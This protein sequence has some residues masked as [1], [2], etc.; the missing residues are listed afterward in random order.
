MSNPSEQFAEKYNKRAIRPIIK[1]LIR[2]GKA[3]IAA[4]AF[5]EIIERFFHL[6]P[7]K[8]AVT[9]DGALRYM[10]HLGS[11]KKGLD[12]FCI[13]C[14]NASK[15]LFRFEDGSRESILLEH[16]KDPSINDLRNILQMVDGTIGST[17][18]G[19]CTEA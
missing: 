15:N 13:D 5:D 7:K 17:N 9:P 4:K 2:Q 10:I 18:D 8:L 14:P 11:T 6:L 16:I 19:N 3:E 1:K 12:I